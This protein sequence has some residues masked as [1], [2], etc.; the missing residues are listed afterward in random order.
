MAG[1]G[2]LETI[3]QPFL[4]SSP[5]PRELDGEYDKPKP[6]VEYTHEPIVPE[7]E[8]EIPILRSSRID[9]ATDETAAIDSG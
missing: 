7:P 3:P 8:F 1:L 6:Y 9:L 4:N 5:P 2:K